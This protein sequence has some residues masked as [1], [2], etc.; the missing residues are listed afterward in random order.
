MA[1][2]PSYK[3]EVK[4]TVIEQPKTDDT[5]FESLRSEIRQLKLMLE[6]QDRERQRLK[7]EIEDLKHMIRRDR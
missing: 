3:E 6:Y 7:N 1:M 4:I 2:I 5:T